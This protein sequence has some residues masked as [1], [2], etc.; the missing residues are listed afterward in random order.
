MFFEAC[1]LI[2]FHLSFIL[3]MWYVNFHNDKHPSLAIKG[4]IL[5]MWY[6]N[7]T[8]TSILLGAFTCFILTMW[9]V[10]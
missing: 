10:N 3:T 8:Y 5:T 4:F 2:L 6:V 1:R 7:S 9:Y